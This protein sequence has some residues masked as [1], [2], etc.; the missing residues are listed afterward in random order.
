M[1]WRYNEAMK[2]QL[3]VVFENG[4]LRPLELVPF[5]ERQ[6]LLVTVSDE[7]TSETIEP[8]R[9]AEQRWLKEQGNHF[10][11]EWVALD[12]DRLVSHGF[13]AKSVYDE[14]RAAGV[15]RPFFV[16]VTKPDDLPLGGW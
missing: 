15:V 9:S 4:V 13:D 16:R 5:A 11:N 6:Q 7:E 2:R 3:H 12:G 1:L 14:A 10:V 8:P